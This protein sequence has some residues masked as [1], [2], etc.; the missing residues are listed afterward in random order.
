M[1]EGPVN[2]VASLLKGLLGIELDETI[3]KEAAA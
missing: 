2:G 1:P 3:S